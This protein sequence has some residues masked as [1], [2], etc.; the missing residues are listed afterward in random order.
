MVPKHSFLQE[1]SSCSFPTVPKGFYDKV[2]EGSIILK[3]A[4]KFSFY[5]EG[6]EVDDEG[7]SLETDLVILATGFDGEKKLKDIFLSKIFQDS[8]LGSSNAAV[9]LYRLAISFPFWIKI[10]E[11]IKQNKMTNILVTLSFREC[12]HPRIPQLAVI[13]FSEAASNLYASELR[14]RWL[15]ELLVGTFKT[16]SIKEMEK[17][18]T[19]WDRYMKQY[20]GPYYRKACIAGIHIWHNDQLCKDMGWNPKRKKGFFAELFEPYGP[21]DY[22]SS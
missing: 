1:F 21:I 19:K 2:E 18:A 11:F 14:C 13:G 4:P 8:V 22:V 20:A 16:P 15:A 17:D 10:L 9:P 7:T 6:I 5:K 12:I 3:K